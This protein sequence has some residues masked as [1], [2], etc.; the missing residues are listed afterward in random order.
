MAISL[1]LVWFKR[2]HPFESD[3]L[4]IYKL[5]LNMLNV[6]FAIINYNYTNNK[7]KRIKILNVNYS[8]NTKII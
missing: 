2:P 7:K 6:Y 1:S 8:F 3:I 4:C 5:R